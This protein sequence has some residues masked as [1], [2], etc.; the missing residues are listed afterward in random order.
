LDALAEAVRAGMRTPVVALTPESDHNKPIHDALAS[1]DLLVEQAEQAGRE[2]DE[3]VT[4]CEQAE[5]WFENNF[6]DEDG[7]PVGLSLVQMFEHV[8]TWGDKAWGAA[9]QQ[10]QLFDDARQR[11]EHAEDIV[12][13]LL[14]LA[15]AKG[16][17]GLVA[18]EDFSVILDAR[19][20]V[21]AAGVPAGGT[22]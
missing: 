7:D 11:L 8:R 20:L 22:A 19:R 14:A 5:M 16:L 6:V 9:G 18:D 1:L 4:R 15:E 10:A 21:A 13:A 3:A 2:R 12:A 17:V